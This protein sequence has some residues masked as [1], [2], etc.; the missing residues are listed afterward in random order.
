[1]AKMC[2]IPEA[3]IDLLN[4]TLPLNKDL[5]YAIDHDLGDLR[6][7]QQWLERSQAEDAINHGSLERHILFFCQDVI[8]TLEEM[9]QPSF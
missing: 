5:F 1:M 3:Y 4:A 8:P 9:R 2:F 6:V 7:F